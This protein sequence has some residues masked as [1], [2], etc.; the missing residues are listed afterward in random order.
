MFLVGENKLIIMPS[1]ALNLLVVTTISTAV[2]SI[3]PAFVSWRYYRNEQDLPTTNQEKHTQYILIACLTFLHLAEAA[4]AAFFGL[5][6][7]N[8][9]YLLS[10]VPRI[11]LLHVINIFT[12]IAH[13]LLICVVMMRMSGLM[14]IRK[15]NFVS[16][17]QNDRDPYTLAGYA[18]VITR[19]MLPLLSLGKRLF[20]LVFIHDSRESK[21]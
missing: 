14:N 20:F 4:K 21:S 1:S 16:P 10:L 18:I 12:E 5:L 8:A 2:T 9:N 7:S 19:V 15:K 13:I 3:F 6:Y 17:D 11:A